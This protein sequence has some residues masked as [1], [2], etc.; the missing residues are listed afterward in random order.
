MHVRRL[1]DLQNR[2][3]GLEEPA[4]RR[5]LRAK[6]KKPRAAVETRGG[7]IEDAPAGELGRVS[8]DDR[9]EPRERD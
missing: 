1:A 9:V 5:A 8:V 6:L 4:A 2:P 3:G 7:K